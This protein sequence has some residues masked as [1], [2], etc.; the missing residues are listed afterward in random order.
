M[1]IYHARFTPDKE[2]GGVVITFPDVPE[3]ITQAETLQEGEEMAQDALRI[4]MEFYVEARE[5]LPVSHSHRGKYF[6]RIH[7]S[8]LTSAKL[9]LYT[10]LRA[11]GMRK[12]ELARRLGIPKQQV[13]R[14]FTLLHHSRVDQIEKA[15]AV[16]GK[17]LSVHVE[18]A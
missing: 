12:S 9:Q 4:A 7:L 18:A 15:L 5:D 11:A 17:K 10:A 6:H 3:A 2:V 14:L 1:H 8:G 13:E 16:L